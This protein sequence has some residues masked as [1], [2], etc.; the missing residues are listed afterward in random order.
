MSKLDG[1]NRWATKMLVP[2]YMEALDKM[3]LHQQRRPRPE[4]DEQE[5][6]RIVD[7]VRCSHRYTVPI[8]VTV[9]GEYGNA[10]VRGIVEEIRPPSLTIDG[11]SVALEDIIAVEDIEAYED[12]GE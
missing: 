5:K 7:M 8:R 11:H 9:Y 3:R 12:P 4:L 1:N 10:D 6:R 2:E